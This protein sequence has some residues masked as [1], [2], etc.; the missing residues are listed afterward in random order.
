MIVTRKCLPRRTIL[1]GLGA[2]IAL[3]LLDGMV[4]AFAGPR[5]AAAKPVRRFGA[6][7]LGNGM[8][9]SH[10]TPAGEGTLALSP[11]LQPLTPFRERLVVVSGLDSKPA[12]ASASGP[13][14]RAQAAWLTAA[15][16]RRSEGADI[17]AGISMDQ[18]AAKEFASET[19]LAS[20]ELTLEQQELG[21]CSG[22]YSCVYHNT[23]AW[24]TETT[25]L[26]ME[27]NPRALF[28]RLFGAS[29]STD[30][31]ARRERIQENRSILDAVSL[32]IASLEKG[33]GAADRARMAE[34]TDTVRDVE[35][36]LERADEQVLVDLPAVDQPTGIP[37]T[38]EEHAKLMFDLLALAYQSD[39]TRVG[40][41]LMIRESSLRA[42]PEIGVPDAH[43]PLSHHGNNAEKLARLAKLNVFHMGLFAYFLEKLSSASEGEGSLLDHTMLLLGCGM[44]DPNLHYNNNVPTLL[45]VGNPR[46]F[47]V[48]GGRHLQCSDGTPLSNLHLTLLEKIGV[49]AERLGDSTGKLSLLSDI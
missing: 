34:Y 1:R 23:I 49:R 22:G 26:P 24:R 2:A 30:A 7:Y 20:I 11:T 31:R 38:Y 5:S 14:A 29:D 8:H 21:A 39:L 37:S 47:G 40:T 35:R 25:P 6:I 44:S 27:N 13:H 42:Y 36:R 4:P 17:G 32:K 16:A 46:V 15:G 10:W 18:I 3:P 9:M 41:F 45:V 19:Q 48:K 33:L 28:E 12:A 43:H